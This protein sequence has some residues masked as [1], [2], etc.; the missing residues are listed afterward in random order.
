LEKSAPGIF[1]IT[2]NCAHE[3]RAF[4]VGRRRPGMARIDRQIALELHEGA[5]HVERVEAE[6]IRG[7]GHDKDRP[8]REA[9]EAE[10]STGSSCVLDILASS[11]EL[12]AHDDLERGA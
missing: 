8:P 5:D 10:P 12:P 2:E 9:T 4:I 3:I 7:Y 1:C 6:K 11:A